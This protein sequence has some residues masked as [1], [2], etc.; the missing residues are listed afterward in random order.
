MIVNEFII[1]NDFWKIEICFKF[2]V[3]VYFLKKGLL[4]VLEGCGIGE[5]V[6]YV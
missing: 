6:N 1:E 2:K 3:V 4:M 5:I